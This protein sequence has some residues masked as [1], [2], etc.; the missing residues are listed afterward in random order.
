MIIG[1]TGRGWKGSE[2]GLL[3]VEWSSAGAESDVFN[4]PYDIVGVVTPAGMTVAGPYTPKASEFSG[5][6]PTAKTVGGSVMPDLIEN[7]V[8]SV[9]TFGYYPF[10]TLTATTPAAEGDFVYIKYRDF[11]R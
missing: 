9:G 10:W 11:Q 6:A 3:K 2:M 1:P 4:C 5:V 8:V 7:D